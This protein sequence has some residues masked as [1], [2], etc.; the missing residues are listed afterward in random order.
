[1]KLSTNEGKQRQIDR[2]KLRKLGYIQEL[3]RSAGIFST[4]AISF[5]VISVLSGLIILYGFSFHDKGAY[6]LIPWIIVGFFQLIVAFSLGE[7]A[8]CYP[9]AGGIYEWTN[10]LGNRSIGWFNGCISLIGWI[11]CTL[12]V[13]FGLG[14]FILKLIG[15]RT[16]V[17]MTFAAC[18]IIVALQT[19][20]G[21]SEIKKVIKIN[22]FGV[23]VHIAGV[24]AI[25]ILMLIFSD[26]HVSW[27]TITTGGN[28]DNFHIS[29][30]ISP[31][32]MAAWTLMAFDSS[33]TISEE[34]I[35]PSKTVPYG[36]IASVAISVICG[37]MILIGLGS[38][39]YT[40][41]D[42]KGAGGEVAIQIFTVILGSTMAK[43]LSVILIM[44]Q[45]N[46]GLAAQT[47]T[48]RILYAFSRNNGLPFSKIFKIVSEPTGTPIFSIL[49]CGIIQLVTCLGVSLLTVTPSI[50]IV[51]ADALP[52]ITSIS[53][54]GIYMS[55]A[56]VMIF[57]IKKRRKIRRDKG[58]F[59]LGKSGI[60]LNLVTLLWTS[61][62]AL[63]ML[64]FLN[65]NVTKTFLGVI[66]ILIIY[67]MVKMRND[68]KLER[69][70]LSESELLIIE[71]RRGLE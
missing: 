35:N 54:I 5:S 8:S 62:I 71:S 15:F 19:L 17:P 67:Y 64:F 18:F 36:M 53:T 9:V 11:A 7:I 48:V 16:T 38:N 4:F 22:Y 27:Q 12:G 44:A 37:I 34:C 61:I 24:L 68:L 13:N 6:G 43:F 14:I 66:L 63:I 10:I 58:C 70:K 69:K 45:F 51:P 65:S 42:I 50:G 41:L 56:I 25:F 26:Q 30:F 52:I 57:S 49:L 60:V 31:L 33:A 1:M 28:L 23:G 21:F 59:Y 32:L 39:S 55:Y 47:V 3:D 46:C 40:N 2:D 20:I 29:Y